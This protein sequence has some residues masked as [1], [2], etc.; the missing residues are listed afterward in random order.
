MK[1]YLLIERIKL[2]EYENCYLKTNEIIVK[3][4]AYIQNELRLSIF[5]SDDQKV[6]EY[7]TIDLKG[8]SLY[9]NLI[10]ITYMP[11]FT[12]DLEENHPLLWDYLYDS[13]DCELSGLER[14]KSNSRNELIGEI[15]KCYIENTF[16][17]IDLGSN[18]L[19]RQIQTRSGNLFFSTNQKMIEITEDIFNKY[20]VNLLKKQF[21]TGIQKGWAFKPNAKVIL[22]RNPFISSPKIA[23]GQ[24]YIVADE[25]IIN[26]K[27]EA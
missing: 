20:N 16:G 26:I 24:T 10:G 13:V 14:L 19:L 23:S 2:G 8:V 17:F 4:N 27:N 7:W 18:P 21:K 5:I 3:N 12:I 25:I 6:N 9:H 1:N 15:A 22:F 11:Y